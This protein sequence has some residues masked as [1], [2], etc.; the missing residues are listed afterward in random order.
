MKSSRI[1]SIVH[2]N[3]ELSVD[4]AKD[5]KEKLSSLGYLVSYTLEKKAELIVS[6]GGDGTFLKALREHNFPDIP[7]VGINTGHLGFFTEITPEELDYLIS[8]YIAKDYSIQ[9]ITPIKSIICA[10]SSCI[11][12]M[13]INEIVIKGNKSHVIHLDIYVDN[14]L[15]QHFSGD[16]ILISTSTGSTAYNYSAGGSII[17]PSLDVLQITPL[18]PINTN[19]YR[20]FTSSIIL[21]SNAVIKVIPE[22]YFE[23]SLVIVI[24]GV[25]HRYNNITEVG[26]RLANRKIKMLRL[27]DFEFWSRVTS[28]FL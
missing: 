8:K 19:V 4:T 24:D 13:G 15:V 17:D 25:E 10:K 7:I 20:S 14:N 21:P 27:E 1:I 16:G 18:A 6:I 3:R 23:S 28:K 22:Y 2:N 5:L 12:I 11:K 9:E 26:T